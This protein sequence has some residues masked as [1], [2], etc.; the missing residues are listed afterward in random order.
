MACNRCQRVGGLLAC[1]SMSTPDQPGLELDL[2]EGLAAVPTPTEALPAAAER[3]GVERSVASPGW[4]EVVWSGFPRAVRERYRPQGVLGEG[5]MGIVIQAID[6]VLE[7]EV[8]VKGLRD[9]RAANEATRKR[10]AREACTSARLSHPN[11]LPVFDIWTDVAGNP[12]CSML[13][14]PGNAPTLAGRLEELSKGTWSEARRL[15]ELLETFQ[16]VGR[17]VAYA[18]S[19][20]VLHRDLKP[21]NI[22]LGPSGE[23]LVADWGLACGTN[24]TAAPGGPGNPASVPLELVGT[25]GF[26]APEQLGAFGQP[27]ERIRKWARTHPAL[28]GGCLAA[29][30]FTGML[31][32][33]FRRTE[34]AL[35]EARANLTQAHQNLASSHTGWAEEAQRSGRPELAEL[36]AAL[37]LSELDRC[38]PGFS[39]PSGAPYS[40]LA[41]PPATSPLAWACTLDFPAEVVEL[42]RDGRS[43]WAATRG[44]GVFGFELPLGQLSAR[45]RV[46]KAEVWGVALSPDRK[47]VATVGGDKLVCLWDRA[48]GRQLAKM[49]GNR[50]PLWT[51]AFSPDGRLLATGGHDRTLRFWDVARGKEVACLEGAT[52]QIWSLGFSPDG[53]LVATGDTEGLVRIWDVPGRRLLHALRG[54]TG[55]VLAVEFSPDS[56]TLASGSD[57]RSVRLWDVASE[58]ARAVLGEVPGTGQ[59]LAFSP[60]GTRLASGHS[61][62]VVRLWNLAARKLERELAGH[63]NWISSLDFSRDGARLAS[64]SQDRTVRL[65]DVRPGRRDPAWTGHTRSIGRL[66]VSPDGTRLATAALDRSLR[67]WELPGG[68]R[69]TLSLEVLA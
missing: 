48:S 14:V 34:A 35:A 60:D 51:V 13:R 27:W 63:T 32:R 47:R 41:G 1:L 26:A 11:I 49:E 54:H 17:A 6:T 69:G 8:A 53:R 16:Q 62:Y 57:D 18:H 25:L 22:L 38:P 56:G 21:D 30:L 29:L 12:W 33:Q 46:E 7:R 15:R 43:L 24:P 67:L 42:G 19:K 39:L 31:A 36:H 66:A 58:S 28:A 20:G 61:D 5:G 23:A 9:P 40:I 10:A 50:S 44:V 4:L 45:S 68:K 65:W 52:G 37:A 3:S 64:V 2:Y 59:A 55:P